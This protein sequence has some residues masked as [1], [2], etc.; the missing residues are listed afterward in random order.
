M[1]EYLLLYY[2]HSGYLDFAHIVYIT[3]KMY[4]PFIK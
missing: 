4:E 2:S 1:E 3:L